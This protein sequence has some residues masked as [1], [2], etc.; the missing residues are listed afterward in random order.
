MMIEIVITGNSDKLWS[1]FCA[2]KIASI[3]IYGAY[4]HRGFVIQTARFL[5]DELNPNHGY[6]HTL[7]DFNN[8]SST[9]F[10]DIIKILSMIKD[11]AKEEIKT[12]E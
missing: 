12:S 8:D 1:L 11:K 3:E 10:E 9:K 6:S 7:M 2:I 4:N 5:I